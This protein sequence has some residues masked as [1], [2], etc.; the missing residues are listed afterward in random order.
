MSEGVSW[1]KVYSFCRPPLWTEKLFLTLLIEVKVSRFKKIEKSVGGVAF[2]LLQKVFWLEHP[3]LS[4]LLLKLLLLLLKLK[5]LLKLLLKTVVFR[6]PNPNEAQSRYLKFRF[7][8]GLKA[9]IPIECNTLLGVGSVVWAEREMS[10][11]IRALFFT[12]SY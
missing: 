6:A 7:S 12:S 4:R 2:D 8:P 5:L 3:N 10:V 9:S 1:L 11:N